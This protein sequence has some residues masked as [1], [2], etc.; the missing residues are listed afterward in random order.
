MMYVA[1]LLAEQSYYENTKIC[2]LPFSSNSGGGNPVGL[3][4]VTLRG[5]RSKAVKKN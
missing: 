2:S 3:T 5:I 4:P 1:Q